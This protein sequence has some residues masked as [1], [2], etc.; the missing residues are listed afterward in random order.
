[1]QYTASYIWRKIAV[2]F[3]NFDQDNLSV[4]VSN[5]SRFQF[6]MFQMSTISNWQ[7][8]T[9]MLGNCSKILLLVDFKSVQLYLSMH[10]VSKQ[11]S[12]YNYGTSGKLIVEEKAHK[13]ED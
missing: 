7:N 3:L 2:L 13:M 9:D 12:L 4:N 11:L 1:M 8:K 6:A 10:L 5:V